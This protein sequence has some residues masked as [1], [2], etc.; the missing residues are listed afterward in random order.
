MTEAVSTPQPNAAGPAGSSCQVAGSGSLTDEDVLAL[1]DLLAVS[2]THDSQ[3]DQEAIA[4]AG[5]QAVQAGEPTAD[6]SPV[7]IGEQLPAGPGLAAVLAQDTP[8]GASDWDLPGMAS[9]Y[10]RLAAW[11]Q[12]RELAAVAEIAARRAAANPAIGTDDCGQPCQLPPEAAAEVALELRMTQAGASA[13]TDLG[14]QLRWQVPRTGAAL[15]AGTIDLARARIIA[16]G[17]GLLTDEHAA[18]VEGRVL[19]SAGNQTTGQLRTAVRRAVL[20]IDPDGAEQRRKATERRAKISLYPDEDGTATLTGSSLPGVQAAA[21]MARITAIARALKSS[22]A[23]GG[24]DLLRAHVF[25]GL[26]LG[27]L[28][29]IPP[30]ADGP[31]DNPPPDDEPGSGLD[32]DDQSGSALCD[33]TPLDDPPANDPEGDDQPPGDDPAASPS[34]EGRGGSAPPG[35]NRPGKPPPGNPPPCDIRP[36]RRPPGDGQP[37]DFGAPGDCG[38]PGF[39]R[40]QHP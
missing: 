30:P 40:R 3:A 17:T 15:A 16:E 27:T 36:G 2:G 26:L 7:W 10:R 14:C 13:W 29:F 6:A 34:N 8:A 12:A 25:I 37:D 22:G 1:L 33:G 4:E 19:P 28:P 24:L 39:A 32:D 11:A 5:W 31:P 21:A 20:A 18:L 35:D 38:E 9:S 23:H